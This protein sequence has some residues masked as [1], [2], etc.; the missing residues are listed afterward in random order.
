MLPG[1]VAVEHADARRLL[2]PEAGGA[3]I[4]DLVARLDLLRRERDRVVVV[5]IIAARRQPVEGPAHPRLERGELFGSGAREIATSVVSRAARCGTMR[6]NPSAQNE[7]LLQPSFQSGANMKCCTTSWLRP[8]NR[9]ARRH[10]AARAVEHIVL[11]DLDPGQCAALLAQAVARPACI[12]SHAPD[13][14]CARRSIPRA[15]RCLCGCMGGSCPLAFSSE[16]FPSL[17]EQCR[18][19]RARD[20]RA[21]PHRR[22]A[23]DAAS[24]ACR[25]RR[26]SATPSPAIPAP[27]SN[28][29]PS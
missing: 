12:P 6:S 13:G 22:I 21:R 5:E 4:I 3:E 16:C 29:R 25:R 2:D 9:S 19:S 15:R 8:L 20:R 14:L 27:A 28:A 7:Q 18:S 24:A 1:L 17:I 10:L 11:V 26:A 23:H